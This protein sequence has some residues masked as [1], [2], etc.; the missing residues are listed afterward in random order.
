VSRPPFGTT[1]PGNR[2]D[3]V[4]EANAP[5]PRVSVVVTHYEQPEQLARTLH[6]LGRQSLPPHEVVVADDGSAEPPSVPDGV[7]LVRQ[8][9]L[10]FRAAAARNLGARATTGEVLVFLDADTTPEPGYLEQLTALPALL[11]ERLATGLRRHA[12][13]VG[14][15]P[16]ADI[17]SAAPA[18]ALAPPGWLADAYRETRDLVDADAASHRYAVGAV[19]A[20]TRWWF[21]EIGGFDETFDGYGAACSRTGRPRWPGTTAPTPAP[22]RA[23]T[24]TAW[25][26]PPRWRTGWRHR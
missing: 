18:R 6:A 20:C 19:L 9:D 1:I 23:T 13:L 4:D 16:T 10:G 24:T 8:P 12:D 17:E 11:P 25:P 14:V 21:D 3:L 5:R 26:R 2:W 7:T 22:S 15:D